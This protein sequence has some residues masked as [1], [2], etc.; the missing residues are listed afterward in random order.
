MNKSIFKKWWFWVLVVVFVF[1]VPL[2]INL[3]FKRSFGVEWLAAEWTAGEA[4]TYYGT[5][6]GAV[7]T[8]W[9]VVATISDSRKS[10]IKAFRVELE[11]DRKEK[12][13]AE[14]KELFACAVDEL[15]IRIFTKT[16]GEVT[17]S[18][19]EEKI[20][21][22]NVKHQDLGDILYKFSWFFSINP[23]KCSLEEI[24]NKIGELIEETYEKWIEIK[25]LHIKYFELF[26]DDTS[27]ETAKKKIAQTLERPDKK[28]EDYLK[29]HIDMCGKIQEQTQ[30]LRKL[31]GQEY[32]NM[33]N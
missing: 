29:H 9:A 24:E 8:I 23:I 17:P 31:I 12:W 26:A 28:L 1:I 5:I 30:K 20:R 15:N 10:Q 13:F 11:R 4:L 22:L 3:L 2:I 33:L 27:D 14:P 16:Q 18:N 21:E 6:L 19:A 7:A 32:E 25:E